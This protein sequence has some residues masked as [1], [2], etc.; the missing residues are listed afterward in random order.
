LKNLIGKYTSNEISL[1]TFV[2]HEI[3][4]GAHTF[5]LI[6]KFCYGEKI[7]LTSSNAVPLLCAA[8]YLDMTENY[9]QGNLISQIENFL[10]DRIL[11]NWNETIEALHSCE[12]IL[13]YAEDLD[14]VSA[15]LD[16][17]A[18]KA[19]YGK[20]SNPHPQQKMSWNGIACVD[21]TPPKFAGSAS[22]FGWWFCDISSLSLHLFK[23]FIGVLGANGHDP[24]I[25]SNAVIYYAGKYHPG[26]NP[27]S[28]G[29]W[30]IDQRMFLE[31][32]VS[33]LPV[34]KGATSTK[35]L[36]SVLNT[37]IMLNANVKC[38]QS[39]EKIIGAQLEGSTVEDLLVPNL[40]SATE[41]VCDINCFQRIIEQFVKDNFHVSEIASNS[42]SENC[43]TEVDSHQFAKL[44]ALA[45]LFDECLL[46]I[47][48]DTNIKFQ[49]F[50]NLASAIPTDMR[51]S[52][53]EFYHAINSYIEVINNVF[54][55]TINK[56][57]LMLENFIE[58]K[59]NVILGSTLHN[60]L[61]SPETHMMSSFFRDVQSTLTCLKALVQSTREGGIHRKDEHI[62]FTH[63]NFHCF[64]LV[65]IKIIYRKCKNSFKL[66]FIHL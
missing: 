12:S 46:K 20:S 40:G 22:S 62:R 6:A 57:H 10:T 17:L 33:L 27:N 30:P 16:S 44:E 37:S 38:I 23:R 61:I 54:T 48:A 58:C 53:D 11:S 39:L 7:E 15:C 65:G 19:A 56:Y 24:T 1:C 25:V 29:N 66:T 21:E 47:S 9:L 63:D 28:T 42:A 35:F 55:H 4:G 14:I 64:V 3:P 34:Q 31:E 45:K 41:K 13:N 50:Y 51:H 60:E 52:D 32:I 43:L 26:L 49:Q 36:F 5:E 8:Y 2:L 18:Y 59:N